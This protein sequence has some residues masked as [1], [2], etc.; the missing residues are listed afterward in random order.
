MALVL[1]AACARRDRERELA[2]CLDIY[3]TTYVAGRIRDCLIQRYR[4]SPEAANE[5]ERERLRNVHPDSASKGDSGRMG[6]TARE[7]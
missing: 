7:R 3:R 5:A 4:W 2:D 1:V 6:D